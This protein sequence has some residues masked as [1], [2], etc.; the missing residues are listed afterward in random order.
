VNELLAMRDALVQLS[1]T[2]RDWQFEVDQA[3]RTQAQ[4]LTQAA[5]SPHR[6]QPTPGEKQHKP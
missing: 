2:L 3:A 4:Q 5:L 6:L 1:L